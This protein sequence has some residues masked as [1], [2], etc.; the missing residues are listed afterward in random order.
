[1]GAVLGVYLPTIQ[2][3][4]GVLMFVRL[5][6]IV[7]HSGFLESFFMVF[8]CCLTTFLTA[9]SMS[10]IA[11]NGMVQAG[12][13]YFMI[14][15]NLGPEC[16]G[17]V[18]ICFYLAN[19][20]ATDLYLLGAIEILLQYIAPS[21]AMF[22]DIHT[23]PWNNFRLYGTIAVILLTFV[24]A[25]GVRFVQMLAPFSLACVIIS[26]LCIFIGAFQANAE[27][28]DVMICL[29]GDRLLSPVATGA[30]H[31][32][33]AAENATAVLH[34]V[35][36]GW[37]TKNSSSDV[38]NRYCSVV[39][40][41]EICDP[42]F[43]SSELRYI[44][45]IPGITSGVIMRNLYSQ[46]HE[47]GEVTPGVQGNQARGEV[48]SDMSTT[49]VH[50]CA[51]YFP[52]VTG[53]MTGSNMSGDLRDPQK[54]IP[55]GTILAQLTC[56][57]V[58]LSFVF[59]FG[60]TTEGPLLRDKFGHSLGG[61]LLSSRIAWPSHWVVLVGGFCSTMGAA[62]QCL[63]SAPRLLQ[64]IA[65]DNIIPFLDVFKVTTKGGEPLR[66]LVLTAL[67]AEGG[68]LI[69]SLD[70][71]APVIDVFFLMCYGFVN[72]ACAIQT[73]MK[74]PS[75]RPRFK[76]Y[77]W[78]LSLLGVV[79]N[80]ALSFI[81]GWY[82]ALAAFAVAAFIYKYVEYK[83]GEKEWGDGIR[84]LSM[85]AAQKALLKLDEEDPH[86]KNWRPQLLV[87]CKLNSTD[88]KP[89]YGRI[90]NL[91]S[92]LK[93]GM[94]LT[95]FAA[96]LHGDYLENSKKSHQ[97]KEAMKQIMKEQKVKGF[98]KICVC[99]HRCQTVGLGGMRHNTVIVGWPY[100]W[101]Q[102]TEERSWKVFLDTVKVI[103]AKELALL[104]PRGIENFPDN[105]TRLDGPIDVWWIVHDGG[106]LILLSFLLKQHKVWKNC[107][108]RI[109]TVAQLA[110]N[111]IQ[112]KKDLETFLY[113]L[114]I[115]A[116]VF[117]EEMYDSD[118]SAYTV[119]RTLDMEKR[120]QM[121]RELKLGR[122][123]TVGQFSS[124]DRNNCVGQ[125][126]EGS[127]EEE[128]G[129]RGGGGSL[130][131]NLLH[132][133]LL[134]H[135]SVFLCRNEGKL[136]RMHT[137][138]RLNSA[139]RIKSGSAALVIINFPAPPAKLAAEENYMEY[140]EAL[141]EGLDRVLMVRGSGQEVVTI[142]S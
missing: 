127:D 134:F 48:V 60:A 78:T 132:H 65:R 129:G 10:A 17:A 93:A 99:F 43:V 62:L 63:T 122:R 41:T 16:G 24:V 61:S 2:H 100:G 34:D 96:V 49:F 68:I 74:A 139:I 70:Y 69:A 50:L 27:T 131:V 82:F 135:L 51:I 79:L 126:T 107:H 109:F 72:L 21:L 64:A 75:W 46:Y 3:I 125:E 130:S 12:G 106:M 115:N 67:I 142:Y 123:G 117:V 102:S 20:F 81:A 37:C 29:L 84:G 120:A 57:F 5:A 58:Y 6:W 86:T 89:K 9:I 103:A 116:E 128:K 121:L 95:V 111:S 97:C 112:L 44:P 11:T 118:I 133:D 110:D 136:M 137:A 28:R 113:Q 94:G 31:L 105:K 25:V 8:A 71:V 33:H 36:E 66:A 76:Y 55:I 14:S 59:F 38:W 15:R 47:K 77:H 73:L 22:G 104:V 85:S 23:N 53:I 26:V 124:Q 80:L 4:F 88:F 141:T 90:F 13:S 98:A 92:Q 56:S 39:N 1:M 140:L 32:A 54:S 91:A 30:E 40:D 101:R 42:F 19:T 18:G 114:R 138:V 45:G 7:G 52:S 35:A 119:E 87:L 83:G 108:L